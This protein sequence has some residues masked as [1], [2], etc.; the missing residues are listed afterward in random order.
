MKPQPTL[1]LDNVLFRYDAE[2]GLFSCLSLASE[3][4]TLEEVRRRGM[5]L[6]FYEVTVVRGI[7]YLYEEKADTFYR[8]GNVKDR[9]SGAEFELEDLR[10]VISYP[11][12]EEFR[13]VVARE[14]EYM[15][16]KRCAQRQVDRSADR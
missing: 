2:K 9:M 15:L 4:V 12:G 5:T 13:K 3:D 8:L 16:G 1:F 7:P 6:S 14:K 10:G 11:Y